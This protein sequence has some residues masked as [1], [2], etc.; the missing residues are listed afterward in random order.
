MNVLSTLESHPILHIV[1][2]DC[3]GVT[4]AFESEE[5][6]ILGTGGQSSGLALDGIWEEGGT[7]AVDSYCAVYLLAEIRNERCHL[8]PE[9]H[10]IPH[11]A[12]GKLTQVNASMEDLHIRVVLLQQIEY[13]HIGID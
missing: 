9:V 2:C 13:R 11:I 4:Q 7:A 1:L 12:K 5:V 10:V 3:L 8:H 6:V